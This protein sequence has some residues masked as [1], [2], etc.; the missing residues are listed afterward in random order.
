MSDGKCLDIAVVAQCFVYGSQVF[1]LAVPGA[2]SVRGPMGVM[3]G[4][5]Q[6]MA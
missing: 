4:R 2:F 1:L 6:C 5:M 3:V